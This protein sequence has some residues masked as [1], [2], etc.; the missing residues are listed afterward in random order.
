MISWE[1]S[2]AAPAVA[3]AL[4]GRPAAAEAAAN[5]P[6]STLE[7]VSRCP[8]AVRQCSSSAPFCCRAS[9]TMAVAP[10]SSGAFAG[11]AV[12]ALLANCCS[13]DSSR[14]TA[15]I[16]KA[17]RMAFFSP[18]R[19]RVFAAC[20]KAEKPPC[21]SR[22]SGDTCCKMSAA[23][24]GSACCKRPASTA[25]QG[26]H[27]HKASI[28]AKSPL[29]RPVLP[30]LPAPVLPAAE[31]TEGTPYRRTAPAWLPAPAPLHPGKA[32]RRSG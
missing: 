1:N 27:R 7:K 17:D 6:N 28:S 14:Q 30:S 19:S 16:K 32:R 18:C 10:A 15:V 13:K 11:S 31:G 20:S 24:S 21:T 5:T 29:I 25:R 12:P 8:M 3:T 22:R 4:A 26:T 23:S 2:M 9:A